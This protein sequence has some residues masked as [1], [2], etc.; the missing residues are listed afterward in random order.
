[1]NFSALFWDW[2]LILLG[3]LI[4]VPWRGKVRIRQLLSGPELAARQRMR[5]YGTTI[6]FQWLLTAIVFWRAFA[7]HL[8]LDEL[9]LAWGDPSRTIGIAVGITL[10]LCANQV[11][12]LHK[13]AQVPE[14]HRGFLFKFTHRIMP[15]SLAEKL[16]FTGLAATAG[17]CEEFLY[18]GFVFAVFV[19]F[20]AEARSPVWAAAL[21][22]SIWFAI[23]HIYQGQRGLITTFIVGMIFVSMRIWS[24]SL[25]PPMLAHAL[26][27][28]VAGIYASKLF[29]S[30]D[31]PA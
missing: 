23:G 12:G 17:I 21:L 22:S 15:R 4:I 29:S 30:K 18:R 16:T 31:L 2:A 6:V 27:D 20:F 14:E 5:L 26:I 25:F 1:M 7:R 11:L 10:L 3:L 13:A 28:L 9:G 8:G 19:R 24:H